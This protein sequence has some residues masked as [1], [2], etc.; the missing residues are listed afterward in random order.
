ME[1]LERGH[2]VVHGI[3]LQRHKVG[4][5]EDFRGGESVRRMVAWD[6]NGATK[7]GGS[8]VTHSMQTVH[9][10]RSKE[11]CYDRGAYRWVVGMEAT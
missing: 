11:N 7:G 1:E 2:H 8:T 10:R 3:A 5:G 4:A 9:G 6:R